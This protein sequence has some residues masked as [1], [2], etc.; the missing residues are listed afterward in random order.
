MSA[1]SS[2][3]TE[4]ALCVA[5][6]ANP[7]LYKAAQ[8]QFCTLCELLDKRRGNHFVI[9]LLLTCGLTGRWN[10]LDGGEMLSGDTVAD[11]KELIIQNLETTWVTLSI[12][13][14][15]VEKHKVLTNKCSFKHSQLLHHNLDY[16]CSHQAALLLL[17]F[18]WIGHCWN[19]L[20]VCAQT[21]SLKV[22]LRLSGHKVKKN[23]NN[24]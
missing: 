23:C 20:A 11:K 13:K 10:V 18:I 14:Q 6:R 3:S 21:D 15:D 7:L 8:D 19:E 2:E 5:R 9:M 12:R 4:I 22:I 16:V 1:H 24:P 17:M